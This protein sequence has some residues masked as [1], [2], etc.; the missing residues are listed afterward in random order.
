[1]TVHFVYRSLYDGPTG[2][3]RR[4]F[5]DATVVDWFANRWEGIAD[6]DN[7]AR[8]AREIL[9]T[10]VYSFGRL[11]TEIAEQA[12]PA[13]RTIHA[14]VDSL[15]EARL[16]INEVRTSPGV[17]QIATDDDEIELAY[18]FF[19]DRYLAKHSDRAAYLL[20]E[21]W[22]MPAD[23]GAGGFK[24]AERTTRVG[25]VRGEGVTYLIFHGAW[26]SGHL[27]DGLEGGYRIDGIR[28]PQLV[29]YLLR[30]EVS[31]EGYCFSYDMPALRSQLLPDGRRAKAAEDPFLFAIREAPEDEDRWGVFSDWLAERGERSAGIFL[32][33]RAL[34]GVTRLPPEGYPNWKFN[35]KK[36]LIQAEDH[37][38]VL[39]RNVS[40]D[41]YHQWYLFDDLWASAHPALANALLRYVRRWD[42]L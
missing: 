34:R 19:D 30:N 1:M 5:D 31:G 8:R 40:P 9:G 20:R 12:L 11:F 32:L 24:P 41:W 6:H 18:Y 38:A 14:V 4:R 3:H 21:D 17:I 25:K 15:E 10:G 27:T 35:P 37:V 39:C 36:S 22:R 13:P 23:V 7:A 26:D 33:E 28:L 16:Y 2:L 42:V 29:P